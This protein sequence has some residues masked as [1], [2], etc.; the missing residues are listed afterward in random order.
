MVQMDELR[1]L[2]RQNVT[3]VSSEVVKPFLCDWQKMKKKD[4]YIPGNMNGFY[5]KFY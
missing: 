5:I 4:E 3:G 2:Q 1:L